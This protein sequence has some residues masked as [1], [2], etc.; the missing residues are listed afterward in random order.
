M[1]HGRKGGDETDG[2]IQLDRVIAAESGRTGR[3]SLL[4]EGE[5]DE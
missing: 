1:K 2:C 4:I 5:D 3:P